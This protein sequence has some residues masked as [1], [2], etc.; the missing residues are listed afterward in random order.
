MATRAP[1]TIVTV[2]INGQYEFD[3]P[4]EYLARKYVVLT[5]LGTDRQTLT[6]N[7]DYRFV[8]RKRVALNV[9]PPA[10][11]N[12][13][14]IRRNT[15]ATERL[16]DFN[17]GSILRAYDLNLSQI[18]TL[19]VAEEAR[20][21]TADTIGVNDEGHLD[22]RGR[23]IVNLA[24]AEDGRDAVTF[25]QVITWSDSAY[26]SMIA[27]QNAQV[28]AAAHERG[29]QEYSNNSA[30]SAN[31]SLISANESAT[32]AQSSKA[33]AA[34]ATGS[35]GTARADADRAEAAKASIVN[36]EAHTT[37]EANRATV[38]ANRAKTEADK[39]GNMNEFAGTIAGITAEEV[40]FNRGLRGYSLLR[41][42]TR[43]N[44]PTVTPAL[45][46]YR[47]GVL[48]AGMSINGGGALVIGSG[49]QQSPV[50]WT[51]WNPANNW[52]TNTMNTEFSNQIT[53]N[54]SALFNG[55]VDI[56]S[57]IQ[58]RGVVM[59]GLGSNSRVEMVSNGESTG[60]AFASYQKYYWYNGGFEVG[61]VRGNGFD[62]VGLVRHTDGAS[63]ANL[64]LWIEP[65]DSRWR[66]THSN[67]NSLVVQTDGN[68]WMR[69]AGT[70]ISDLLN[71]KK[72]IRRTSHVYLGAVQ[73]ADNFVLNMPQ[74]CRG[75]DGFYV[76]SGIR[77]QFQ[78][79]NSDCVFQLSRAGEQQ[80]FELM[81]GG[82]VLVRRYGWGEGNAA[83][84]FYID[85]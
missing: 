4:F 26:N 52:M 43:A 25:G 40:N 42:Y 55:V 33:Y 53:V 38:E 49:N 27:A 24:D 80:I 47:E 6:L 35:A 84:D 34:D 51:F 64:D 66:F 78:F 56:H 20:D 15:S 85:Q 71:R 32:H 72:P 18:Q 11:Y 83:Y 3:I 21:L 67:G 76:Y 41:A 62:S 7:T 8:S 17:D 16:V 9:L 69:W 81:S 48:E 14:E 57:N 10:S 12:K 59:A 82:T 74:D 23:K 54:G 36:S 46:I 50:P 44:D 13:L 22:A 61:S 58:C 73:I 63:G 79:P 30:S 37:A 39:L 29:A 75:L 45:S 5:L 77:V 2:N 70:T 31:A 28:L 1:S 19:H 68:L 60:G 65:Q